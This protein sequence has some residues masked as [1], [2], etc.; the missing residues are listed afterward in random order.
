MHYLL[1]VNKLLLYFEIQRDKVLLRRL[2]TY[3]INSPVLESYSLNSSVAC[4]SAKLAYSTPWKILSTEV[5][6]AIPHF[7]TS[8]AV[9]VS[10]V[11]VLI[12]VPFIAAIV[13]FVLGCI[14]Y[15]KREWR[16]LYKIAAI[17]LIIAG[18][19]QFA[20]DHRCFAVDWKSHWSCFF[21]WWAQR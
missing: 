14:A 5:P 2:K 12:V 8:I 21:G 18:N 10:V 13:A 4:K 1:T 9:F 15:C 7:R 16:M 17:I 6:S 3:C 19:D 11:Q 20:N